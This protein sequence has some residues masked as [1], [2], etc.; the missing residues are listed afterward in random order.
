MGGRS[1]PPWKDRSTCSACSDR[2]ISAI[3]PKSPEF[4]K[5]RCLSLLGGGR[6]RAVVAVNLPL[7]PGRA[8]WG[9][10]R[11]AVGAAGRCIGRF[12]LRWPR[13]ACATRRVG[14]WLRGIA[15]CRLWGDR[16]S[17]KRA[18]PML[19]YVQCRQCHRFT[20]LWADHQGVPRVCAWCGKRFLPLC[21]TGWRRESRA[22]GA[23]IRRGSPPQRCLP[24]LRM[25]A[26]PPQVIGRTCR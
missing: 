25:R 20:T 24:G 19:H 18:D 9:R 15:W 23:P 13:S 3:L 8:G 16:P 6:R 2:Q 11:W 5:R 14:C 26:E 1:C 4:V 17:S 21:G 22:A 7:H 10:A 12:K